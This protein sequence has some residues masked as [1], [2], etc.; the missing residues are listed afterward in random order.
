MLGDT[1]LDGSVNAA[2]FVALANHFNKSS[3]V[4]SDGD[5]NYDGVVN[6]ID[7]NVIAA[8]YGQTLA[9]APPQSRPVP[10]PQ[11]G[12]VVAVPMFVLTARAARGRGRVAA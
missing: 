12:C 6:A 3:A 11:T 9:D 7:F 1:N 2:D 8:N 4:W 5:V 10:E